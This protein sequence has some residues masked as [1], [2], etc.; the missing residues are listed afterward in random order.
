[1]EQI[2][3]LSLRGL[4][5]IILPESSFEDQV[6]FLWERSLRLDGVDKATEVVV[7]AQGQQDVRT[8]LSVRDSVTHAFRRV[9]DFIELAIFSQWLVPFPVFMRLACLHLHLSR[10]KAV[11]NSRLLKNPAHQN[12]LYW[13]FWLHSQGIDHQRHLYD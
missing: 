1:M 3:T 9:P 5:P 7:S 13:T 8:L 6:R 10:I 2:P 12:D 11:S 4:V